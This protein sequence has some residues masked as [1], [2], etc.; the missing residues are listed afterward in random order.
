MQK[1]NG[2]AAALALRCF[3]QRK[4]K[5]RKGKGSYSRKGRTKVRL[6]SYGK[7]VLTLTTSTIPVNHLFLNLALDRIAN[8]S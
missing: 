8:R 2:I 6:S 3:Q 5:P 4:V 1:R 7:T